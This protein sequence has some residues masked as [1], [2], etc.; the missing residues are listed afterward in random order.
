MAARPRVGARRGSG[1]GR[2]SAARRGPRW[3]SGAQALLPRGA[4]AASGRDHHADRTLILEP[5]WV[6]TY[7]NNDLQLRRDH[8]VVVQNGRIAAIVT[9]ASAAATRAWR[10]RASC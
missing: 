7:E 10:C 8:S 4:V 9:G 3:P 5:S 6:L 1:A 2:S